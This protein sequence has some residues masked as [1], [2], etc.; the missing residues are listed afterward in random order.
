M[1]HITDT[2]NIITEGK[3]LN[4]NKDSNSISNKFTS[5][6]KGVLIYDTYNNP[7]TP[8]KPKPRI[9]TSKVDLTE[10]FKRYREIYTKF[11]TSFL[12]FHFCCEMVGDRFVVFNTRPIDM[13]FPMTN[14]DVLELEETNNWDEITKLYFKENVFDISDAIHIAIIGDSS[15]DIYTKQIYEIIG[16]TCIMPF[17]RYFKLPEGIFQRTFPLN[18]GKKFNIKY[19]EKYIKR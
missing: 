12:P 14:L 1:I 10:V 5:R 7:F 2:Y 19:I 15:L 9:D 18:I 6:P 17:M 3:R 4:I 13:K 11:N 8:I 16:R